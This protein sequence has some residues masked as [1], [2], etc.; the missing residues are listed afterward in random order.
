MSRNQKGYSILEVLGVIALGSML[1]PLVLNMLSDANTYMN[2]Q[3]K[4][5]RHIQRVSQANTMLIKIRHDLSQAGDTNRTFKD[6]SAEKNDLILVINDE[7]I[8][9]HHSEDT[10][11][12]LVYKDNLLQKQLYGWDIHN[13]QIKP[14]GN[15]LHLDFYLVPDRSRTPKTKIQTTLSVLR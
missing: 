10:I 2:P 4:A 15:M 1:I 14:A 5:G 13:W 8:V 6:Y 12:R 9:W 11:H 3:G 7:T